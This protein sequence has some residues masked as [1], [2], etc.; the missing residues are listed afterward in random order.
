LEPA[1]GQLFDNGWF[2]AVIVVFVLEVIL[3]AALSFVVIPADQAN[4]LLQ[5][6]QGLVSQLQNESLLSK[7][8]VIFSN[9]VRIALEE[10]VPGLGWYM[11]IGVTLTTGEIYSALGFSSG[12]PAALLLVMTFLSPH[13][14]FELAAYAVAVA[15]SFFLVNAAVKRRLRDEVPRATIA[16]L[17]VVFMLFFAAFLE[18]ISIQYSYEGFLVAWAVVA[19]AAF[20]LYLL[21]RNLRRL[22][23]APQPHGLERQGD[24]LPPSSAQP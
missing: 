16:V 19:V 1:R 12:V 11:F 6:T 5:D 18:S 23:V 8:V 15:E 22:P 7:T 4:S 17:L 24:V 10:F 3:F 20:P 14:W 9:N 21:F 13:S 2:K